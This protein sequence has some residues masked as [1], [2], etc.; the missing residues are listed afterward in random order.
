MI[1]PVDRAFFSNIYRV[2]RT[3]NIRCFSLEKMT[4]QT[5]W[6]IEKNRIDNMPLEEKRQLYKPGDYIILDKVDPWCKFVIKN[7]DIEMLKHTLDDLTEFEKI[8]LDSS[9]DKELSEKVSI[10][11]GDI[12]KLEIDAIVNA[13]NSRLIAGGGVDGAIHRAAGPFL[14]E[15]CNSL[16]GCATG[17]AKV[18]SGYNLPAKYVIH[19]VGPRDGSVKDLQSCYDK[20]LSFHHEYKI[21]SIAFPCIA[22]G[23]YGFPNRLAAHIA[24]R[25]ARKFLEANEDMERII[26]CT[27]MPVDVDIYKTLMQMYFPVHAWHY[28]DGAS[29][30]E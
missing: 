14:Q 29:V 24:L 28:N 30:S 5:K 9:K 1:L 17:D 18:T 7:K 3:C 4:S 8:K 16:H 20:S 15:E 13:A 23:I 12:T 22:T 10:F 21:K 19:T 25:T 27:F 2:Y 26:F 11:Q 6:K